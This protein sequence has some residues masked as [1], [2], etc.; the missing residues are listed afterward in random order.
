M[1]ER[2]LK[3][4]INMLECP[5]CRGYHAHFWWNSKV[6]PPSCDERRERAGKK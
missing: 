4:K 3:F 2:K 5:A 1:S 6:A